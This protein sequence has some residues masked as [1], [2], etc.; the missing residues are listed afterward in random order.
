MPKQADKQSL[1]CKR[2]SYCDQMFSLES[3]WAELPSAERLCKHKE[4]LAPLMTTFFDWC[5][6]QSVL[7]GSKLGRAIEI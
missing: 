7:P 5:R 2:L 1:G 4:R 6:N 3:S